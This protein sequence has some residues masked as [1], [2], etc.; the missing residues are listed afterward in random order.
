M[1]VEG[2]LKKVQKD[3]S[4]NNGSKIL[5]YIPIENQLM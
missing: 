1:K 2:S 5:H 3:S 4:L